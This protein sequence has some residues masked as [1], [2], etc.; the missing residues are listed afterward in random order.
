[1]HG[2]SSLSDEGR[3]L[4]PVRPIF[5]A[6]HSAVGFPRDAGVSRRAARVVRCKVLYLQDAAQLSDFRVPASKAVMLRILKNALHIRRP[7][8]PQRAPFDAIT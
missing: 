5:G 1:M 7:L 2:A 6:Q 4:K 8:S 3:G